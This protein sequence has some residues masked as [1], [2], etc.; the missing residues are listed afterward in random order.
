MKRYEYILL[1]VFLVISVI[2]IS[3]IWNACRGGC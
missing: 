2:V 1:L 3:I